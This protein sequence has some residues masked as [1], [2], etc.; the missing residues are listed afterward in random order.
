MNMM[1]AAGMKVTVDLSPEHHGASDKKMVIMTILGRNDQSTAGV[2]EEGIH[3]ST[4][5]TGVMVTRT[6]KI[7]RAAM[8]CG[9][10]AVVGLRL[11]G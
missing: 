3:R 10:W 7:K 8:I 5:I 1:M 11:L 2:V 6:V 4:L 9:N